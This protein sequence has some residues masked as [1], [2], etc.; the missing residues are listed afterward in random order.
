MT[1][2]KV[3][4]IMDAN[5][6]S[7]SWYSDTRDEKGKAIEEFALAN[8]LYILNRS[9]QPPT[10]MGPSG[11]SNIDLTLISENMLDITRNWH[12]MVENT[13]SDHNM[14]VFECITDQH[15]IRR[16]T[17]NDGYNI[18][19]ARWE[20]FYDLARTKF[21]EQVIVR[22]ANADPDESVRLFNKLLKD[23]RDKTIPKRRQCEHSVPWWNKDLEKLRKEVNAN[24]KQLSRAW[25][26]N[27][28][29]Q[30]ETFGNTYR[31][32]RNRY[33]KEIRSAERR[34][35]QNFVTDE[36]NK[37]PWGIVYKI[38]RDKI[39]RK[40]A[41][42]AIQ[43]DN[44]QRTQNIIST[45]TILLVK[46]IP[47][48]N[49]PNN[50]Q[51]IETRRKIQRYM[52]QNVEQNISSDEIMTAINKFEN[53]NAAGIDNFTIEIIKQ[54][55]NSNSTAIINLLNNCFRKGRFS[56][57]WKVDN[58]KILLKNRDKDTS[59]LSSYRPIS[60]LPV[61]GKLFERILVNRIQTQ[62][63]DLKLAN[64][65]QFG[66]KYG[67]ST[68]DALLALKD[69]IKYTEK[70]YAVAIFIDIEGAFDNLW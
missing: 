27:L 35:W 14:I 53:K 23:C 52:C 47:E 57:P 13:T 10:Y 18:H 30:T 6:K 69:A 60:L 5:A 7:T 56:K 65:N 25:Q 38:A 1:D 32:S 16:W 31:T 44:G 8:N 50:K 68:E 37:D 55:W 64:T 51:H 40:T 12:V 15:K 26:L 21:N 59:L 4:I 19:K 46:C 54:L 3:V 2:Q 29:D 70:K 34:T 33:V 62:Y 28:I 49:V 36:G 61:M 41:T 43:I 63:D 48:N 39:R 17:K 67:K 45:N 9:D 20:K 66:Y 11:T 22:I 58:L 24:K 42:T